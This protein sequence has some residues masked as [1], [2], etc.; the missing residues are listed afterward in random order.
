MLINMSLIEKLLSS[1]VDS[2]NTLQGIKSFPDN[3]IF[4]FAYFHAFS[5]IIKET[6]FIIS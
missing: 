3:D 4:T 5:M 1:M 6:A 2:L